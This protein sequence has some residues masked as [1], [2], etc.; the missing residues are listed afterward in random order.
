[1]TGSPSDGARG[2]QERL[3]DILTAI[4]R[5][6]AHLQHL[7][8]VDDQIVHDALLYN[9]IVIGEAVGQIS[10]ATRQREPDIPWKSIKGLRNLLT[11]E[12][13]AIRIRQIW[14]IVNASVPELKAA[15]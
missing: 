10:D 14:D 7:G 9:L 2:D 4:S 1:M 12:Y 5:I 11:H 6:D 3:G 15:V 13:F 8:R